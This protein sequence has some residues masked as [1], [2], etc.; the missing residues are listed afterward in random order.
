MSP[1]FIVTSYYCKYRLLEI[2]RVPSHA[3]WNTLELSRTFHQVAHLL[4]ITS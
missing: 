2:S 1:V 3:D 4:C